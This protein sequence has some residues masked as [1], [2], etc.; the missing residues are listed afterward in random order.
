MNA[1]LDMAHQE[2]AEAQTLARAS[3]NLL[4]HIQDIRDN[5][6]GSRDQAESLG[7][8]A[9]KLAASIAQ[10]KAQIDRYKV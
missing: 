6:G 2:S 10:L 5:A 1:M 4:E 8:I 7:D 9:N 3:S